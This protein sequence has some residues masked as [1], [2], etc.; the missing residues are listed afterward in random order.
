M[1]VQPGALPKTKEEKAK[2]KQKKKKKKK[3]NTRR[4]VAIQIPKSVVACHVFG[5]HLISI[6]PDYVQDCRAYV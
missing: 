1:A 4:R 6:I 5:Q 3:K 2:E